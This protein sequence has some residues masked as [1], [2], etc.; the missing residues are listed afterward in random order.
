MADCYD[1]S[2]LNSLMEEKAQEASEPATNLMSDES[3]ALNSP[4][5]QILDE[6]QKASE[7]VEAGRLNELVEVI[8]SN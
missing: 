1:E 5:D 2:E 8:K 7:A 4:M 6:E 3:L